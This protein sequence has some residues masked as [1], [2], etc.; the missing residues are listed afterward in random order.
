[1]NLH[2]GFLLSFKMGS[3]LLLPKLVQRKPSKGITKPVHW[4]DEGKKV[5]IVLFKVTKAMVFVMAI[6][7]KGYDSS[8]SQH[9]WAQSNRS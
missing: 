8:H 7:Q 6:S 3:K 5:L 9:E 4:G 2:M 1:M